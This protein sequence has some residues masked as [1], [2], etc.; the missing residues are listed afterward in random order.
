MIILVLV[1]IPGIS[2]VYFTGYDAR[3]Q[4]QKK[5]L[6]IACSVEASFP[7]QEIMNLPD[8][9]EE[10]RSLDFSN[11]KKIFSK[12]VDQTPNARFAY[13]LIQRNQRL[14]FL[15]DSEPADSPDYSPTGQEFTEASELDFAP[16]QTGRTQITKPVTDRWGTWI[17]VEVPVKNETGEVVA[18]FGMDYDAQSWKYRIWGERSESGLLV[19]ALL[20][21]ILAYIRISAKNRKLAEQMATIENAGNIIRNKESDY[22]SLFE[23]NPQPM[24]IYDPDS[25]K[26]LTTNQAAIKKYG[27]TEAEFQ[28]MTT[29]DLVDSSWDKDDDQSK[30]YHWGRENSEFRKHRLKSG[31]PIMVEI[32]SLNVE[33]RNGIGKLILL[34]DITERYK[35][36]KTLN[37]NQLQLTNL[38][39]NLPG[40]VYHCSF[41][42]D[43]TM[44]FISEGCTRIT[45]Y[46]PED[47]VVHKTISFNDLILPEYQIPIWEKWQIATSQ[48]GYFEDNYP[49][50]TASGE[51]RWLWER[52]HGVFN[53]DGTLTHLEGYIEDI[54][55][56]KQAE[57]QLKKLSRAVEQ[58]PVSI[59]I[60][61]AQGQIEYVNPQFTEITGY[62]LEEAVGKN[63]RI[64][65]SGE[66]DQKF[67]SDLWKTITSG[68]IWKGEI[69]NRR[70]S[71]ELY[72]AYK[73]IS[74][75][76]DR[77]GQI[78]NYV[79]I[80]EDI[81]EKKK[82]EAELIKA[83]EKA[84][85]SDRLKSAFL[86]N[87]SHEIRTPMNGL[88][89]FADLLKS[90]DLSPENQREFIEAIEINGQRMLNVIN[91]LI[92]ISKIETGEM[93]L[94]ISDVSLNE[95]MNDAFNFFKPQAETKQLELSY[96]CG[97]PDNDCIIKS[98]HIKLN[99]ILCNLIRNGLKFTDRGY[100]KFEYTCDKNVV[101]FS[102][103]D[104]GIGISDEQKE[105]IFDH[106]RQGNYSLT[107]RYEGTGLGLT[108][109]KAYTDLLGGKIWV[110]SEVSKGSTF[111]VELPCLTRI[112]EKP[113]LTEGN[114]EF[115]KM[116]MEVLIADDDENSR[117]FIKRALQNHFS[118]L[119]FA[120][121]GLEAVRQMELHPNIG[122]VLMDLKMPVMDGIEA[123]RQI[124]QNRPEIPVIGQTA[125]VHSD[126]IQ[127]AKD[128]GC[129][130]FVMKPLKKQTLLK[131]IGNN[132]LIVIALLLFACSSNTRQP[133]LNTDQP[134]HV[135]A[136]ARM[137]SP[138]SIAPPQI[139]DAGNPRIVKV[140]K[141]VATESYSNI[142]PA[143][144]PRTIKAGEPIVSTPGEN[145]FTMPKVVEA[146][147]RP[148]YS[149]QPEIVAVKDAYSKDINPENFTSFSKLQGLKHD[150]IR[151]LIQDQIGNIWFS[152]DDGVTKYDGTY[153]SHYST[154]QGLNN[155]LILWVMQDSKS[156][157]W[158]GTFK[159]GV[160][161]YDGLRF[162]NFTTKEGL[163][164][165]I[166]NHVYEDK[167]G[168]I[169][170]GTGGGAVKFD[171]KFFTCFNKD[172]GLCDNDVRNILQD[173]KGNIWIATNMGGVSKFDGKSFYNYT[174]QQGMLQNSVGVLFL[175]NHEN[176]WLGTSSRGISK[177]DGTYFYNYSEKEGLSNN[178]IK[179]IMQDNDGVLWIGTA[180]GGISKFDGKTFTHFTTREG[181]STN[182]IR[183]SLKDRNGNLW[184]G[185]RGGGVA[186]YNGR[187]FTHLTEHEGLSNSRVM[188]ILEDR[189]GNFWFG[190]FGGF[191]TK[192]SY[193]TV[194]GTPKAFFSYLGEKEGIPHNRVYSIIQDRLGNLWFGTD[195]GGLAKYDGKNMY[196][197][198]TSNGL[199]DNYIRKLL[200]DRDGNIWICTY[201]GGV[202]KFDGKQFTNYAVQ[203]GLSSNN[204]MGMI[205]DRSGNFW[206]ATD[207]GGVTRFDGR[208]FTHYTSKEGMGGNTVYCVL[209][210]QSGTFWF[211]TADKGITR[212]DGKEFTY[213]NEKHGLNNNFVLNAFQDSK[214]NIWFG[215]RFGAS[216]LNP[217]QLNEKQNSTYQNLFKNYSYDEGFLGFGINLGAI[218]EDKSGKIW[219]GA[220]DRLTLYHPEGNVKDTIPPNIQVIGVSL[221]NEKIPWETLTENNDTVITLRNG[222]SVSNVRLS[223]ISQWNALPT[224]LSLNYDNNFLTFDF[225]AI[226][227]N[228]PKQ[229]KYQY[230]LEG[231]DKNWS[232]LTK[233]TEATYGNL[234]RGKY[235]F[236]VKAVN[237]EGY[238]SDEASFSFSIRPPWWRTWW[239]YI[240]SLT[241]L[242]TLIFSYIK[243]RELKINR[244]RLK[245]QTK[246]KEQTRELLRKN[247]ELTEQ[248]NE[249]QQKNEAIE[250]QNEELQLLNSEKDKFFS[251]I[252]HDVRGPMSSF[253]SLTEIL[254]EDLHQMNPEDLQSIAVSMNVS[255]RN[256]FELLSNLLEWSRMQRGVFIYNP[257]RCNLSELVQSCI[258]LANES[259]KSKSIQ[260]LAE[261]NDELTVYADEY[262]ISSVIRNLVNNA[263]KFTLQGGKIVIKAIVTDDHRIEVLV[264]DSGIGIPE[265]M[266]RNLFKLNAG[267]SRNGTNN[268]P[269]TGLGLLICKEFLDMHHSDLRV[270]SKVG[271]GTTF[272]FTLRNV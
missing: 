197:Y 194:N 160:T 45:G 42:K 180:D 9:P 241:T 27:Y 154:D 267:T 121:N 77:K 12:V 215:T 249:I 225:I 211:G 172:N 256:L 152:T 108:I 75:I 164:S 25:L 36:E 86:A 213:F 144:N 187:L 143:G 251:I 210:D 151:S 20:V 70:K 170:F 43:Y 111:W 265:N 74:P 84:E 244:D 2:F 178:L 137:I 150:Q 101:L 136:K 46:T 131:V 18:V 236:R 206:F 264:S 113:T 129:C 130:D 155:S 29:S 141:L 226:T 219:F 175:D 110:E 227:Q 177:F 98:D 90:S 52:G 107:R 94:N 174:V 233:R 87:I 169:W 140:G 112:P 8:D 58:N 272:A 79:A 1:L 51:I 15:V 168:N 179:S 57:H 268:E 214:Q 199:S 224:G 230:K 183:S 73:S 91:D 228:L 83:K 68:G 49:I 53:E 181:L 106:F 104:S 6:Q 88:L 120:N 69:I 254:S 28:Q 95:M 253:L 67:Y 56:K 190:T 195:G 145:N 220:N 270:E 92:D 245:L 216:L 162:T 103:S 153:F 31:N 37:E 156:N 193:Q 40:F 66:M 116:D 123:T 260:I 202:S 147:I 173:K 269:S 223:G 139:I 135:E 13:L 44:Q 218:T 14:Y 105:V 182:V 246:V 19:L 207:G 166:I 176:L 200:E 138:D 61:D 165:D 242:I 133:A 237:S 114:D 238:W 22:R 76:I 126:D 201:G 250:K 257:A 232:V 167:H 55:D 271:K 149:H 82:N 63:P 16:F 125:F 93:K 191:V 229:I 204:I 240:L 62:S 109:A 221:F 208:N 198:T 97:S 248:K 81:T 185:T 252:A 186:R 78:L 231:F 192:L 102:V 127:R 80:G 3:N 142:H 222:L 99:Q 118:R 35:T 161:K 7:K 117:V 124:K 50:R 234:P 21:L 65:K 239:F 17:S 5:A 217:K 158:F 24:M 258:S 4:Q 255:A 64:L 263:V 10:I 205:Q 11:L 38:I 26:I 157:L 146:V 96:V 196:I 203:S 266:I 128:A 59:V 23:L 262:M 30:K 134:Q 39:S 259:A 115:M 100:V 184:F 41:D 243:Q 71:G 72:W 261:I 247:E 159:G 32:H 54:T 212:F 48:K 132:L 85:E 188:S 60:T 189:D 148:F 47:F 171:G 33:Y 209:E 89:G 34:L 163:P 119:H 235:T 122:V